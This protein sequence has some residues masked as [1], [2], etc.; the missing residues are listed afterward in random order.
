MKFKRENM[1]LLH[2]NHKHIFVTVGIS[3]F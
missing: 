3:F 1:K 2:K